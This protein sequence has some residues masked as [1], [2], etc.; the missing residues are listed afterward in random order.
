MGKVAFCWELGGAFGHI[1]G[2]LPIAKQLQAQGHEV[3]FIVKDLMNTGKLVEEQGFKV[4]QAPYWHPKLKKLPNPVNY[5]E[6]LFRF[7]YLNEERLFEMVNG[8]KNILQA[9][10]PDLVVLDHSPTAIV[11][12]RTITVKRTLLGHG[13]FSPPQTNPMPTMRPWS[14]P[15]LERLQNSEKRALQSINGVLERLGAS[16]MEKLSDLFDCDENFLAT[17][18]ELDHYQTR[19]TVR[20]WGP[21][22]S[23]DEGE[24]PAWPNT[25]IGPNIFAYLKGQFKDA[26]KILHVLRNID[27]NVLV[28]STGIGP[29]KIK[30][31]QSERLVFSPKM[32]NLKKVCQNCDLVICH[33][34]QA[35]LARPLLKG[36]PVM[37]LPIQLEQFLISSHVVRFGAGTM[38]NPLSKNKDYAG[39]V[40]RALSDKLIKKKAE[41]FAALHAD[42]DQQKQIADIVSRI[43]ELVA[44]D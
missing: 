19:G 7:G 12:S 20:Y 43:E 37:G 13:F 35:T 33:G 39:A 28:Y 18:P 31:F 25:Q 34:G 3:V 1:M 27:A 38:V 11:A 23:M 36:I 4:Y 2:F 21:R 22:M 26:E 15:S 14:K 6:I 24:D 9:I 40:N 17:F 41:E 5:A 29:D 10:S 30:M 42:F 16:S 8:W 32:L 44:A